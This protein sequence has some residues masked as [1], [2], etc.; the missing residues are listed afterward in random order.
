MSILLVEKNAGDSHLSNR[1]LPASKIASDC[2]LACTDSMYPSKE[3][4]D[5]R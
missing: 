3:A 1:R 2:H 5:E 4:P